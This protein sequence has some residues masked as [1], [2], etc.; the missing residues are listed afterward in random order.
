MSSDASA[1]GAHTATKFRKSRC[2]TWPMTMFCGLPISVAA[3]PALAAPASPARYG[4][5]SRP[6]AA[7]PAHS[8]GVITNT[9][10]SLTS[11]ADSTPPSATVSASSVLGAR[12]TSR[13]PG[14][15]RIVEPGRG[16]ARRDDHQ[17]EQ[18]QHGREMD[19]LDHARAGHRVGRDQH[20]RRDQRDAAA[21]ELEARHATQRHAEIGQGENN[22]DEG[23]HGARD[24]SITAAT[25]WEP[26][27]RCASLGG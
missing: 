14:G 15:A 18:Q 16:E 13:D 3:E 24:A 25:R 10:T 12:F 2:P 20:H 7:S 21:I 26:P 4:R 23:G 11:T 8:S 9:T 19:G 22:D 27:P 6:R 17:R 5:T 1:G